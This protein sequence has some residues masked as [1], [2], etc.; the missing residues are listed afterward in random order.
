MSKDKKLSELTEE[1][2]KINELKNPNEAYVNRE[3][4]SSLNS[5]NNI[6][7]DINQINFYKF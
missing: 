4:D 5:L 6:E 1:D 2:W 7:K 3:F